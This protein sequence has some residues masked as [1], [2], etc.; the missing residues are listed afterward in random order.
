MTVNKKLK[1]WTVITHA[2]IMVGFGHG[3]L[4][5]LVIEVM[6][7][8]YVSSEH[9]SLALSASF[10]A[11]LPVIGLMTLLGQVA[12]LFSI[13]LKQQGVKNLLQLSGLVLCWAGVVYF[14]FDTTKDAGIHFGTVTCIPFVICTLITFIGRP[15]KRLYYWVLDK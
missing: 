15:M 1:I 2:F 12:F 11:H 7:F 6:W 4:T 5:F 8:P 14:V 10:K 3:I 13:L 9:F